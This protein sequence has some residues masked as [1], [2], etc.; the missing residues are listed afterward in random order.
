MADLG[1]AH[2]HAHHHGSV[3]NR[4]RATQ[5]KLQFILHAGLIAAAFVF[6]TLLVFGLIG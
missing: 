5:G 3:R 1:I 2:T 4:K 6:V